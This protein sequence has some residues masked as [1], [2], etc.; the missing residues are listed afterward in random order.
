MPYESGKAITAVMS[1]TEGQ[2]RRRMAFRVLYRAG[3]DVV[4][5]LLLMMLK[6]GG[7]WS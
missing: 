2:E 7:I 5:A 3:R 4:V 6:V 1:G